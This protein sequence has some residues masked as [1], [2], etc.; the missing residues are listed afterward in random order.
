MADIDLAPA[1]R[2]STVP[3]G[4]GRW[5]IQIGQ[6]T[7]TELAGGGPPDIIGEIM[8][9]RS[10]RLQRRLNKP[11]VFTF[12]VDG[13]SPTAAELREF[14]HEIFVSR[15][16]D[17]SNRDEEYFRGIITHS[18]DII[19]EQRHTVNFTAHDVL[20]IIGRRYATF[21]LLFNNQAQTVIASSLLSLARQ[22]TTANGTSLAP[23]S[24][25]PFVTRHVNPD[26]T[27]LTAATP[28]RQRTYPAGAS[29]GETLDNLA[30]VIN[31]FDYDAVSYSG[32][33]NQAVRCWFPYRGVQRD[34]F[35]LVYGST[36][37]SVSRTINSAFYAN[38]AMVIGQAANP[39]AWPPRAEGWTTDAIDIISNPAGLWMMTES[40]AD[41]TEYSTLVE[42]VGALLDANATLT[43]SYSL[44]LR[45]DAYEEGAPSALG[46]PRGLFDLGDVVPLRIYSGRLDVDTWVRVFGQTFVIGDDGQEDVEVEV[47]RPDPTFVGVFQNT[48]S[49][50]RALERR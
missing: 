34:D 49:R 31:G 48:D 9:A 39:D 5:R 29:L 16:S 30:N 43:P 45:G 41:V 38:Y 44:G 18:Q 27:P 26:G 47:G 8:D 2:A 35:A 10:R 14:E 24:L 3:P 12:S 13:R 15:W 28:I 33:Q 1:P 23:G 36:V 19:S 17:R 4:R 25:L 21:P 11:A 22:T 6:R 20:A 50:L 37:S 7:F 32:F 40:A 46:E 42:R